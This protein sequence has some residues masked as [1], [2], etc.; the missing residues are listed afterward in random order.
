M[1]KKAAVFTIVKDEARCL[2]VFLRYYSK[3]FAPEDIYVLDHNNVDGCCEGID[4]RVVPV[5][6]EYSFNHEWLRTTVQEM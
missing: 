6:H 5:D 3:Y 2:P 4:A 1:K